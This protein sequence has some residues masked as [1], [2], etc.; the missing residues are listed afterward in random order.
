MKN[1]N[2]MSTHLTLRK[3]KPNRKVTNFLQTDS[4]VLLQ[5]F[6]R[7]PPAPAFYVILREQQGDR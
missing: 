5:Y 7:F 6:N 4:P 2:L 1:V 3:F